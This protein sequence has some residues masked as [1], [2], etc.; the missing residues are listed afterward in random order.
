MLKY[1]YIFSLVSCLLKDLPVFRF[2]LRKPVTISITKINTEHVSNEQAITS[3]KHYLEDI[4]LAGY[5]FLKLTCAILGT[6]VISK[7]RLDKRIITL[8]HRFKQRICCM[9]NN[10]A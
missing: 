5:I 1:K 2:F 10:K 6:K 4:N 7:H 9:N 8:L 3:C